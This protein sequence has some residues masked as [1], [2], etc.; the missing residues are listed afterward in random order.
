MQ[1]DMNHIMR[2]GEPAQHDVDNKLEGERGHL[3][4]S[5]GKLPL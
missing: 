5:F 2:L 4:A 3:S 1:E